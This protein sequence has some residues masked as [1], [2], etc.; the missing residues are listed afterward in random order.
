MNYWRLGSNECSN[1]GGQQPPQRQRGRHGNQ[2][3]ANPQ[4]LVNKTLMNRCVELIFAKAKDVGGS[5]G[6][7]TSM[8]ESNVSKAHDCVPGTPLPPDNFGKDHCIGLVLTCLNF[9]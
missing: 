7:K 9:I 2:A 1:R 3:S 6:N 5:E 4:A 8:L